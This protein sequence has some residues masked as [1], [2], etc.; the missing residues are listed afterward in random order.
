MNKLNLKKVSVEISC[1]LP[2]LP[3][4]LCVAMKKPFESLWLSLAAF[5]IVNSQIEISAQGLPPVPICTPDGLLPDDWTSPMSS[6]EQLEQR[7]TELGI[8]D[9]TSQSEYEPRNILIVGGSKGLGRATACYFASRGN[10]VVSLA[11]T[12][13]DDP[14]ELDLVAPIDCPAADSIVNVVYDITKDGTKR[15]NN[16]ATEESPVDDVI[17]EET[18]NKQGERENPDEAYSSMSKGKKKSKD[19]K[20]R[21][22]RR[23]QSISVDESS[24]SAGRESASVRQILQENGMTTIDFLFLNAGRD[25][26]GDLRDFGTTDLHFA[27]DTNVIGL[28]NVW[29]EVRPLLNPDFAL[30]LASSSISAESTAQGKR[31]VYHLTKNLLANMLL[32]YAVEEAKVQ[33]NT[34]YGVIYHG[35]V[36]TNFGLKYVGPEA[37]TTQCK[38]TLDNLAQFSNDF[39]QTEGAALDTSEVVQFYHLIYVH[40]LAAS[41]AQGRA[42]VP[43]TYKIEIQD[44]EP[45]FPIDRLTYNNRLVPPTILNEVCY[46]PYWSVAQYVLAGCPSGESFLCQDFAFAAYVLDPRLDLMC[47]LQEVN[48]RQFS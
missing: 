30:V 39:L 20:R 18:A 44:P 16:N 35:S 37:I 19:G 33:P 28:H 9:Y 48:N 12:L 46:D 1:K 5:P 7:L 29:R 23:R 36:R 47:G 17:D 31:S 32:A 15:G 10:A 11:V 43:R 22:Q 2:L 38:A 13:P 45:P 8:L 40:A 21:S 26:L 27:F 6:K 14:N 42:A 34:F 25:I 41:R 3:K 24:T 4:V